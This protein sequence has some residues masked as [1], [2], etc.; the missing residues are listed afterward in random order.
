MIAK[1]TAEEKKIL[2]AARKK[3]QDFMSDS[4]HIARL[5]AEKIRKKA[6]HDAMQILDSGKRDVEKERLSMLSEMKKKI[7]DVSLRINEKVFSGAQANEEFI[8][9][10]LKEIK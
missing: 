2:E 9:K 6:H 5:K 1:A 4:E 10:E 7:I 3:A 8:E